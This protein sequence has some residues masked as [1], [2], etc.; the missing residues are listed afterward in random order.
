M[1]V[2]RETMVETLPRISVVM[3]LYNKSAYVLRAIESALAQGEAILEVVVV[4]DGSTDGGAAKVEALHDPRVRLVR[5][6]NGGVSSARNRG[7]EE[8]RSEF[9]AFLDADDVYLAGFAD[10]MA[11]L[12]ERFP[13]AIV[14]ATSYLRRWPDGRETANYLPHVIENNKMQ[15]VD[16]AFRAWSRS[17]F[18]HIGSSCVRR[19]IFFERRVFFPL[20]ENIGEDQDV[21]FR[22]ME[23]GEVA[24]S[25]KPLMAYSQGITNSLYSALPDYVLPCYHRLDQRVRSAS[26]PMRHKKGA[27]RVVAVSYLNAARILMDKGKRI[28]A[29]GL[30]FSVRAVLFP[31]YW[32]RTL[33]R[34]SLPNVLLKML[35]LKWI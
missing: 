25:P 30:V 28:E 19:K 34:L 29:V 33:A 2:A 32:L 22:L 13:Q 6:E 21:I 16:K 35:W 7:I 27:R 4:D 18:F 26:Y 23:A 10:E 15:I 5:K 9:V 12:I 17:S 20:G 24:F 14:Y 3:P 8:A 11:N 1:C 31:T